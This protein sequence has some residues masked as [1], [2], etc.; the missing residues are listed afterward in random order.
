MAR[1]SITNA[2]CE[3]LFVSG[4]QRS[5]H[6]TVEQVHYAIVQTVRRLGI[7]GCAARMAQEF[8]DNPEAAAVRMRWVRQVVAQSL[9]LPPS[10]IDVPQPRVLV[11]SAARLVGSA[12]R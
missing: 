4:L 2:R 6:P 9:G 8:G 1:L 10:A 7:R 5:D 3:A 12:A 11:G